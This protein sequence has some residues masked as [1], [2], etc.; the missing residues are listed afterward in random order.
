[1]TKYICRLHGE[2]YPEVPKGAVQMGNGHPSRTIYRFVD[3]TIHVL[4]NTGLGRKPKEK[5][6]DNAVSEG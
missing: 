6:H 5:K 2:Q 3:G 1:M 4:K